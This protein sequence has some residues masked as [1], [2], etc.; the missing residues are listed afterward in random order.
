MKGKE[1]WGGGII[2][3]YMKNERDGYNPIIEEERCIKLGIATPLLEPLRRKYKITNVFQN[4][5]LIKD[6]FNLYIVQH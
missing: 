1:N 6:K 3:G 2:T 4:Q 5:L